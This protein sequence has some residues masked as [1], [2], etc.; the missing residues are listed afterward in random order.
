MRPL[1]CARK[2]GLRLKVPNA[3]PSQ[4]IQLSLT[5]ADLDVIF[6]PLRPLKSA[7][8]AVSGGSDSLALLFLCHQWRVARS[9]P[10]SIHVA[11]VDHGLRPEAASECAFVAE[12]AEKLG[13]DHATLKWTSPSDL[14]NVQAEARTARYRLL[15]DYAYSLDCRHILLAHHQDDQA[16]TFMIRLLRG[17]GVTGLG[18]MRAEQS[19]DGVTLLRPLLSVPKVRLQASLKRLAADWIE[20][21]SNADE[22]FLRVRVRALLPE[23][24]KEGCDAERLAATA[25]RMQR[26]DRA[27]DSI[28]RKAFE[29]IAIKKPGHSLLVQ[30]DDYRAHEEEIRLRILRLCL[31]HVVGDAYPPREEKLLT[32]DVALCQHSDHGPCKRTLGGCCFSICNDKLWIYRELGRV[33]FERSFVASDPVIWPGLYKILR[34]N[35]IDQ[36][37]NLTLRPLGQDGVSLLSEADLPV[38]AFRMAHNGLSVELIHALPSVWLDNRPVFVIDWPEV[39]DLSG[40]RVEFEEKVTKCFPIE[41]EN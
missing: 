38:R 32:L 16:E 5:L 23:L 4:E 27:L 8:L 39:A 6:A 11:S 17:S 7:L 25:R 19:I 1:V 22:A 21:P 14:S 3:D 30:L 40:I 20:D 24:T 37:A 2:C 35:G 33:P 41:T 28:A 12:Q 34:V 13:F 15:S 9:V 29:T 26:A 18:A 10:L 31:V 36:R